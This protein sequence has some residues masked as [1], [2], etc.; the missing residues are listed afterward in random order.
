MRVLVLSH[1]SSDPVGGHITQRD[2]TVRALLRAGVDARVGTPQE[3]LS[4]DFDVVHAFGPMDALLRLGRPQARLVATSMYFPRSTMLGPRLRRPGSVNRLV[5][6]ARNKA[7]WLRHPRGRYRR[8][9]SVI[10]RFASLASADVLVT[11]SEAEARWLRNDFRTLPPVRVAYG[12]VADEMFGGDPQRGREI[13]GIGEEPFV[14]AVGRVE[15]FKNPLAVAL[16]LRGLPYRLVLVG[17]VRGGHEEY[18]A[19][20]RRAAPDL[21]HLPHL[22]HR[23]LRDVYAAAAVHALAAHYETTGLVTL[24]AMAAGTP[25]VVADW[26][27]QR[28]YFAGCAE[29]C[30]TW[31]VRSVRRA[32]LRALEGPTGREVELARHYSWD[33]AAA[34]LIEAYE[35]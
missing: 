24:E 27:P 13:V 19:E 21:I 31:S 11:N 23:D 7:Q 28:E 34:Q 8:R 20:V 10:S 16:A 3:A 14:L 9:Q 25:V 33:R 12:G 15:T 4:G 18:A 30:T 5:R 29:F 6:H 22:E 17:R 32:I 35:A 26:D 1:S 2:E